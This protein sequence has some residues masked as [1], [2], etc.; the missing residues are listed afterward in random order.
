MS[1][2]DF[3]ELVAAV[4]ACR[5]CPRMEGR[6]RVLG[7]ANGDPQRA[8]LLVIAT[9]PGR[10]GAERTGIPLCGDASGATFERLLAIAGLRRDQVFVTNAVLCNPQDARG[11]NA[12]PTREELANC[13]AHLQATL[14][15]VAAPLLVTLGR[16]A[17]RAL[18]GREGAHLT[19]GEPVPWKGRTLLPT[20]HPSPRVTATPARR[21]A[22][23][24]HW[25]SVATLLQLS[26][27]PAGL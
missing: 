24:E 14:A 9:A 7:T 17:L 4:Q 12:E 27:M 18:T 16:T 10:S 23:S 2:P 15:A 20:Y 13:S 22:M 21:D 8:R 6:R 26:V 25:R 11:R 19:L 1:S 3:S 5:A